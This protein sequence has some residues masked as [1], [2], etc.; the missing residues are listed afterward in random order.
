MNDLAGLIP[1]CDY[2]DNLP[3]IELYIELYIFWSA[4]V[5]SVLFNIHSTLFMSPKGQLV[6]QQDIHKT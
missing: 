3:C 5:P 4:Q 6:L 2:S 1:Q